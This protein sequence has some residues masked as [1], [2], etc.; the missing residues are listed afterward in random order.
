MARRNVC[1]ACRHKWKVKKNE[2]AS[3]C[4]KCGRGNV[5]PT[6]DSSSI[7]PK[8]IMVV[9]ILAGGAYYFGLLGGSPEDVKKS[10]ENAAEKAKQA[11]QDLQN[12]TSSDK[13]SPKKVKVKPKPSQEPKKAPNK[14]PKKAPNKAPKKAPA[15]EAPPTALVVVSSRLGAPLPS[16]YLVKGKIKNTGSV[17]AT[18][19]KVVVTYKDKAGKVLG[20]RDAECPTTLAPG[21]TARYE[22]ALGGDEAK[23]VETFEASVT[24]E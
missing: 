6:D 23:Q 19:I 18:S 7:L 4:P 22:S 12:E 17:D 24:F 20:T 1:H 15:A 11:A 13:P 8:L 9:V 14:A 5:G 3:E 10:L 2:W 21:K 16:T